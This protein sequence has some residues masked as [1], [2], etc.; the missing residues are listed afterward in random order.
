[1]K[2]NQLFNVC[3]TIMDTATGLMFH[4]IAIVFLPLLLVSGEPPPV[5]GS[6]C[7]PTMHCARGL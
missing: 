2:D 3:V 6:T 5:L 1:M 4:R 7:S